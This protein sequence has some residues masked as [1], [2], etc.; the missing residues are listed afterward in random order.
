MEGCKCRLEGCRM[1]GCRIKDYEVDECRMEGCGMEW[2]RVK[3]RGWMGVCWKG[4]YVGW[5]VYD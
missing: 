2:G 1:D 4:V 3:V 5:K